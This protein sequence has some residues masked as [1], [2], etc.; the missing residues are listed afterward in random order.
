MTTLKDLFDLDNL[1]HPEL[2]AGLAYPWE[3]I[4]RIDGYLQ[5]QK[6]IVSKQY[7]GAF[8]GPAVSIGEG[9][10]IEPGAVIYGPSVIGRNCRI[11]SGA[12]IRGN[13]VI[14]DDVL[15]GHASEIKNS[16][17]LSGAQIPHFNYVGDSIVGH[18]A[19]LAAGAILANTKISGDDIVVHG[20]KDYP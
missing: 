19:H 6:N 8:V 9:T 2:F 15:I 16:V 14:E 7:P 11:R 5:P 18:R 1:Q 3:I 17:I 12:Y 20:D 10:I 13:A 4:A